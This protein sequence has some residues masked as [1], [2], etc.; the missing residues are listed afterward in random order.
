MERQFILEFGRGKYKM[1]LKHLVVPESKEM[2]EQ[3]WRACQNNT[4]SLKVAAYG[5]S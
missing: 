1:S 4:A 5:Q 3:R 2:L